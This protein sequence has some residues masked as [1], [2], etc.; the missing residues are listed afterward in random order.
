MSTS[1]SHG[2]PVLC[3][4]LKKVGD[5]RVAAKETTLLH[6]KGEASASV[7]CGITLRV[8]Y[9]CMCYV[10]GSVGTARAFCSTVRWEIKTC[11]K[12]TSDFASS[13]NETTA[14]IK[15]IVILGADNS[16]NWCNNTVAKHWELIA[17]NEVQAALHL[18]DHLD[19]ELP[20]NPSHRQTQ[21]I[22]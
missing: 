6:C 7:C 9:F 15:L 5:V 1:P 12:V 10:E 16:L 19:E 21:C 3:L 4:Q 8:C 11:S 18:N 2:V 14:G 20:P 13:A 17:S 22:C